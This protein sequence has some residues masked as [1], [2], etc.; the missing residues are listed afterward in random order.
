M[1]RWGICLAM[2][3]L[4]AEAYAAPTG[5]NA[6]RSMYR[7]PGVRIVGTR[8]VARTLAGNIAF[9]I[10]ADR[11][12]ARIGETV[13]VSIRL[14]NKGAD[15][16]VPLRA[17]AEYDEADGSHTFQGAIG[18]FVIAGDLSTVEVRAYIPDGTGYVWGSLAVGTYPGY[19]VAEPEAMYANPV[20]SALY[21]RVTRPLLRQGKII[22]VRYDVEVGAETVLPAAGERLIVPPAPPFLAG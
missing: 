12:Y 1:R 21:L 2:L 17:E 9:G 20:T 18:Q 5:Y 10:S 22:S 11:E 4:S 8:A 14:V 13:R 7:K 6:W 16:T 15:T 19:E 3:A